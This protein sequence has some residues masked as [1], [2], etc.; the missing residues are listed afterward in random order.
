[1]A[2]MDAI[3]ISQGNDGAAQRQSWVVD[4]AN[5]LHFFRI[6]TR[7]AGPARCCFS[8]K[9]YQR[10]NEISKARFDRLTIPGLLASAWLSGPRRTEETFRS[11][12]A[13][14]NAR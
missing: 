2:Q 10:E 11:T 5:D 9:L 1:M 13:R 8:V 14:P 6:S 3:K 12:P 4:M 7:T